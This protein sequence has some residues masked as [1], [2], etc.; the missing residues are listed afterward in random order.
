MSWEEMYS[1]DYPCKCGKGT[2]TE[3]VEMDDWNR[4][5]EHRTINCPKCAENE[6]IAKINEAKDRERLKQL[7][8]EIKAYS[9]ERYMGKWHS[10]F[11]SARN[12][13]D[14]WTLAKRMGIERNRLSSFYSRNKSLNMEEYVKNLAV[15]NNMHKIMQVLNIEDID[16]SCKIDEVMKLKSAEYVKLVAEWHRNH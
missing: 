2:Y 13:K 9:S 11:A 8:E 7:D 3:V 5:R 12:K 1:G 10:Y 15:S 16:L 4:Q 14:I 6:K